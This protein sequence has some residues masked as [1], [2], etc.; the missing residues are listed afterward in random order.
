M[1]ALNEMGA[2]ALGVEDGA[3][4]T[5]SPSERREAGADPEVGSQAEAA[6]VQRRVSVGFADR[7]TQPGEVGRLLRRE[8]L[9]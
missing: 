2:R 4:E 5:Q 1:A 7:C 8:G 9:A 3:T 6:P